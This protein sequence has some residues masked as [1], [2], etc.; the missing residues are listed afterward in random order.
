M[1]DR[2]YVVMVDDRHDDPEPFVFT[3]AEAAIEYARQ[4]AIDSATRP[5]D[6]EEEPAPDGWLY[7]ARYSVEGDAV[8]VI[9][10][11]LDRA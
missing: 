10:K 8:W 1:A 2:V 9:E 6:V 11:E 4:T 7:H 3:T 5:D